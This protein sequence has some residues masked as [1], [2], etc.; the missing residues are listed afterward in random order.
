MGQ[1]RQVYSGSQLDAM[2][3]N[4]NQASNLSLSYLTH[5]LYILL[6]PHIHQVKLVAV[7]Q[8]ESCCTMMPSLAPVVR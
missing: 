3:Q 8:N 2:S 5:T 1:K 4:I 6:S 7:S